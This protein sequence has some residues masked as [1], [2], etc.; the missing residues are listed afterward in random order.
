MKTIDLY[1]RR[2]RELRRRHCEVLKVKIG[3]L[4]GLAKRQLRMRY[5]IPTQYASIVLMVIM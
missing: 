1:Q 4:F 5:G 2:Y 3:D